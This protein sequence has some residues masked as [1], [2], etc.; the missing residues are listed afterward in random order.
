MLALRHN[1][2]VYPFIHFGEELFLHNLKRLKR[3][4][5]TLRTGRPFILRTPDG[6]V[7]REIR[8]KMVDE[9]MEYFTSL[10]PAKYHGYYTGLRNGEYSY[11][12]FLDTVDG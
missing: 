10:L 5:V 6:R 3:T 2:P 1:I 12:N 11:L 4:D 8:Q 9:M 7:N